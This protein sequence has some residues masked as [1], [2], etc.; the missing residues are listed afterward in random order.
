M[1]FKIYASTKTRPQVPDN[2][3]QVLERRRGKR[4]GADGQREEA[5]G[6]TM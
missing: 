6:N 3:R 2:N 1:H 5:E 4:V